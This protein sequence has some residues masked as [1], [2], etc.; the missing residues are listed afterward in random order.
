MIYAVQIRKTKLRRVS[1]SRGRLRELQ[2][3]PPSFPFGELHRD[4]THRN[5]F[6]TQVAQNI[7]QD[8]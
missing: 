7:K 8:D 1:F 6:I 3:R 2:N 4:P 5:T